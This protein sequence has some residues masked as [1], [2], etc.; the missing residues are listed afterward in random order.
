VWFAILFVK[1]IEIGQVTPPVGI[2]VYVV[3]GVS[4]V[5]APVVFRGILPFVVVD[6][7]TTTILFLFPSIT[8]W[9]PELIG[10]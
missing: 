7:V 4:K 1:L 10:R 3:S 8:L 6:L 2:N 9:L 5:E